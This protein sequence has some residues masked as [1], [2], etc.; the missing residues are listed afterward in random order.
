MGL[1]KRAADRKEVVGPPTQSVPRGVASQLALRLDSHEDEL[2]R[3]PFADGLPS[4][5]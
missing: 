2:F 5:R 1:T 4:A 3:D